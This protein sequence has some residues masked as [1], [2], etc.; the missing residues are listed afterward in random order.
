MLP[1]TFTGEDTTY[2]PLERGFA[3]LVTTDL[4][5][6]SQLQVVE[7]ERLQALLDEIQLQQS[8]GVQGGTGVR[9]GKMLG[10]GRIVGGSIS[11]IGGNQLSANAIVTNVQTSQTVGSGANDQQPMDQ[12]FTLEKNI[13]FKLFTDMGVT[14][15]TAERTAIDQR[16]TRS[17]AAFLAYSHGLELEDAGR[18][19]DAS[20]FF[21]NAVR[22]DPNFGAARQK[23]TGV[24]ECVGRHAGHDRDSVETGLRGTQRRRG[25]HPRP[26]AGLRRRPI[27]PAGSALATARRAE[28]VGCRGRDERWRQHVDAAAE[29]RVIGNGRRQ[30]DDE[31]RRK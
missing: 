30:P 12:I 5:R 18:F 6:S 7:R 17:L 24:Q 16:P 26:R 23:S 1:F 14:L 15:T 25:G 28:S 21:D 13:V 20:R 2:K 31:D 27:I 4:S 22:I 8:S 10:A 9:A 29:G 11:Q 19:D 3:E